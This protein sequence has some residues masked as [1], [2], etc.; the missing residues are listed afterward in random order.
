MSIEVSD[1]RRPLGAGATVH[2]EGGL[3]VPVAVV[4]RDGVR[5]HALSA[6]H[7]GEL[8]QVGVEEKGRLD[9][10]VGDGPSGVEQ[11]SLFDAAQQG[12]GGWEGNLHRRVEVVAEGALDGLSEPVEDSSVKV[13]A[14]LVIHGNASSRRIGRPIRIVAMRDAEID[15]VGNAA[16]H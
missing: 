1:E 3:R 16:V 9:G 10:D 13:R 2:R 6:R 14:V 7:H 11:H 12:H 15:S 5:R 8:E 4:G